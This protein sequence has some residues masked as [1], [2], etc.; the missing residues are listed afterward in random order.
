MVTSAPLSLI[1]E[2]VRD[3]RDPILDTEVLL[4]NHSPEPYCLG[5]FA[6][7]VR[8][9]DGQLLREEIDVPIRAV[10]AL[11]RGDGLLGNRDTW[12]TIIDRGLH[13]NGWT[14]DVFDYFDGEICDR[15]FPAD[16][17]NGILELYSVG[18]AVQ[19]GNGNHRL[20]GAIGWIASTRPHDPVLRKAR[21]YVGPVLPGIIASILAL[22]S[23]GTEMACAAGFTGRGTETFLRVRQGRDVKTYAVRD[24][25]LEQRFD[26][27]ESDGSQRRPIDHEGAWH[28]WTL[29]DQVLN[30]WADAGWLDRQIRS[31]PVAPCAA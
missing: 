28:W 25:V 31:L 13:G 27:R 8:D 20:A 9:P 17:A 5:P 14:H 15:Y 6:D 2:R 24:G 1:R 10:V 16:G 29:P 26:W 11:G 3:C 19:C 7:L 30:A 4:D 12:R 21:V 18:G 23:P 22:R